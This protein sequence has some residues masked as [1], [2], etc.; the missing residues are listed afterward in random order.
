MPKPPLSPRIPLLLLGGY[1]L[2]GWAWPTRSNV[3]AASDQ[4]P[5]GTTVEQLQVKVVTGTDGLRADS[6]ADIEVVY[7]D[8]SKNV[9]RTLVRRLNV[10]PTKDRS[11][12]TVVVRDEPIALAPRSKQLLTIK[13]PAVQQPSSKLPAVQ[14]RL[15]D[16]RQV[17]LTTSV[18]GPSMS[19]VVG[20]SMSGDGWDVVDVVV[21]WSGHGPKGEAAHGTLL[22]RSGTPLHRFTSEIASGRWTSGTLPSFRPRP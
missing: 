1:A 22:S 8:P 9:M 15:S 2:L 18:V 21:T 11:G 7:L 14:L 4:A 10:R 3:S 6:K 12:T 19:G 20:P 5:S 17:N 16:I 13:L